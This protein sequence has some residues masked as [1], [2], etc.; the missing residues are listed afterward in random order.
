MCDL[1]SFGADNAN[2]EKCI[3]KTVRQ[4]YHSS[5]VSDVCETVEQKPVASDLVEGHGL[6]EYIDR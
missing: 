3:T 5:V 2:Y 1:F 6:N 4:D